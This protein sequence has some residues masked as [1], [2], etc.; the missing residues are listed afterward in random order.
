[1]RYFRSIFLFCLCCSCA[2]AQQ[3]DGLG[4]NLPK[5]YKMKLHFGFLIM[6]NK[7]DFRVHTV[8]N[9]NFPDTLI[10]NVR[11]R[12]KSVYP[13]SNVGFALGIVSDLRVHEYL[14]LRFTPNI[15]FASRSLDYTLQNDKHDSTKI[16]TKQVESTFLLFPLEAKLQSKRL[17][18]FSAYVIGGGG[19]ALDLAS[20]KHTANVSEGGANQLDDAVKI[21]RDDYF[22]SAGAGAD[23]YLQYFKFGLE[24]KL[25]MGTKNLMYQQNNIFSKAVDKVNSRM[26]VFSLTFEG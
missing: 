8:K 19:Y 3:S 13:K 23:F 18:N 10:D 20:N 16:F 17:G 2:I 12:V 24:I 11:Y 15:S 22:Y 7:T 1:M 9:S 26:V 6:G 21:K 5:F 4:V 14:R 25:I